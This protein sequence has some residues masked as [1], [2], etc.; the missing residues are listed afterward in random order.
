MDARSPA[1][2]LA[3]IG[4]WTKEQFAEWG[5]PYPPRKGWIEQLI[6]AS[7]NPQ[8]CGSQCQSETILNAA[9]AVIVEANGVS[10]D[11]ALGSIVAEM[12]KPPRNNNDAIT[13]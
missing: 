5:V 6:R 9:L 10:E 4:S 11:E 3:G 12:L 8:V 13:F 1:A 2:K 7:H